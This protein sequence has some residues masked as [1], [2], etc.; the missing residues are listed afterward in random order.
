MPSAAYHTQGLPAKAPRRPR[1]NKAAAAADPAAAAAAEAA[2]QAVAATAARDAGLS[3]W[4]VI[5][6]LLYAKRAP[7]TPD[8]PPGAAIINAVVPSGEGLSVPDQHQRVQAGAQQE[9]DGQDKGG[10]GRSRGST[11]LQQ[12]QQQQQHACLS[13]PVPG[14]SFC[15]PPLLVQP[16]AVLQASGMEAMQVSGCN[17]SVTQRAHARGNHL[18]CVAVANTSAMSRC[19]LCTWCMSECSQLSPPPCYTPQ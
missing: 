9:A 18:P 8:A 4:H 17:T 16:E 1:S 15:R 6:K 7:A 3:V 2:R 5:R 12:Q 19:R 14:T 11:P 13:V 10:A